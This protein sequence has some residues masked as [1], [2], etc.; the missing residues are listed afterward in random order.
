[1]YRG[2]DISISD[3]SNWSNEINP[4]DII[5]TRNL[6]PIHNL[7]PGFYN[8]AAIYCGCNIIIEAQIRKG[9]ITTDLE[10]FLDRYPIV[11]AVRYAGG[12]FNTEAAAYARN[13]G[14]KKYGKL[15]SLFK[16]LFNDG[17]DNCVSLVRRIFKDIGE[18]DTGW[19]VPDDIA[20]D[21][22]VEKIFNDGIHLG[23][24]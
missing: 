20:N 8:H 5:L 10:E 9:V 24:Y 18:V 16:R 22:N 12:K 15:S 3:R 17:A 11:T 19:K 14:G 4:G 6:R 13:F 21:N 1:M 7:T 23:D 2:R